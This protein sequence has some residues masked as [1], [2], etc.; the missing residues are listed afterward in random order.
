MSCAPLALLPALLALSPPAASGAGGAAAKGGG[1][2]GGGSSKPTM[3]ELAGRVR[4]VADSPCSIH[5]QL[6]EQM[7]RITSTP[8]KWARAAGGVAGDPR[9]DDRRAG[10][11]LQVVR[12]PNLQ[13]G[14]PA[15]VAARRLASRVCG[16][17][18]AGRGGT[19]SSPTGRS[20]SSNSTCRRAPA[21]RHPGT[22]NHHTPPLASPNRHTPPPAPPNHHTPPLAPPNHHASLLKNTPGSPPFHP[23]FQERRA[24]RVAGAS[25]LGPQVNMP[26]WV[27][28]T[29]QH[30]LT[31]RSR[32]RLR[33]P[34][35]STSRSRRS[36]SC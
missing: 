12:G 15:A 6:C 5:G 21:A 11:Q 19:S 22:P 17:D 32:G 4:Q 29:S 16:P 7:A 28:C 35:R 24:G 30:N 31:L 36:A 2:A 33:R 27:R 34:R 25:P 13:F 8:A 14:A 23:S 10:L 18:R 20:G 1:A 26:A 9:G 3:G